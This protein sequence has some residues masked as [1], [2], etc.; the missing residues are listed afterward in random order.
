MNISIMIK[1]SVKAY[2]AE[3]LK[4]KGSGIWSIV[5]LVSILPVAL[6]LIIK[7]T[8]PFDFYNPQGNGW[9][10]FVYSCFDFIS[11]FLYEIF[12]VIIIARLCQL[13]HR[14][15]GWKLIETQPVHRIYLYTG[16]FKMAITLSL[17]FLLGVVFFSLLGAT[18]LSFTKHGTLMHKQAIPFA[19]IFS[20][21]IRFWIAGFGLMAF[22]YLLS[23]WIPNF[24]LPLVIGM[25]L[26]IIVFSLKLTQIDIPWLPYTAPLLTSDNKNG[27]V[28]HNWLLYHE[29]LSVIWMLLFLWIGYRH[30]Y[31]KT[32]VR[33]FLSPYAKALKLIPVFILFA[34]GF[35][36]NIKPVK[37]DRYG[38]TVFAG[39]MKT[40]DTGKKT[41]VLLKLPFNDTILSAPIINNKYNVEYT[42]NLPLGEYAVAV[43]RNMHK[44]IFSE[45]D[46]LFTEWTKIKK[47]LYQASLTGTRYAEQELNSKINNINIDDTE[48]KTELQKFTPEEYANKIDEQ[49]KKVNDKIDAFKTADNIK[50]SADFIVLLKKLKTIEYINLLKYVYP[51]SYAF[52]NPGKKPVYP[53]KTQNLINT[54]TINDTALIAFKEY[55]DYL[56]ESFHD[57][58]GVNPVVFD[59]TYFN[60]VTANAR[61]TVLMDMLLTDNITGVIKNEAD[62]SNRN[63]LTLKY[64]PFVT[65]KNMQ[66]ILYQKN[67][68][69]NSFQRG[70]KAPLLVAETLS[71]EKVSLEKFKG[72]YLAIDVW[73]TWCPPCRFETPY[74]EAMAEQFNDEKISFMS[75]SVDEDERDWKINVINKPA[76]IYQL[77]VLD[78]QK[79]MGAYG[80]EGIPRFML[81]DPDG[82]FIN[83]NMPKPSEKEF[84]E[85]IQKEVFDK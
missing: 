57:K 1:D 42:G 39:I 38:K 54:L 25:M 78:P 46:S 15:G 16:K 70:Q 59:T 8:I 53:Q 20:F 68:L 75:I 22:Q 5:L 45:K 4:L 26:I 60:Y 30:Y 51:K 2:K 31:F 19:K 36:I 33:A 23:V 71:G 62:S 83:I 29:K 34:V 28:V 17:I 56:T 41:F 74:F 76:K 18:F 58:A 13:E 63:M 11:V 66:A 40:D 9:S 67:A 61:P 12:L 79:F 65:N 69:Y 85:I 82:K 72:K 64:I 21:V 43:G 6:A 81:I 49:I 14:S 48:L 44:L 32:W 10:G 52:K 27:S 47:S 24:V 50:P 7:F 80:I 3:W 55:R 37:S 84:E 77:R 73:A 35:W